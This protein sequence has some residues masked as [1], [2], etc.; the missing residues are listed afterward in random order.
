MKIEKILILVETDSGSAHV[1]MAGKDEKEII[2]HLLK[3]PETGN[4]SL[5]PEIEPV[6]VKFKK[7]L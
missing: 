4:I 3:D 6:Q 1:L 2:T 7:K 5:S